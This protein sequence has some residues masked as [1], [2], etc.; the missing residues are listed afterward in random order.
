MGPPGEKPNLSSKMTY[1]LGKLLTA[2]RQNPNS[3]N[4]DPFLVPPVVE[5]EED[6]VVEL[7]PEGKPFI[8]KSV[9]L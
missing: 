3:F 7:D 2:S 4:Y 1:L 5:G 9:V 6:E 8:V